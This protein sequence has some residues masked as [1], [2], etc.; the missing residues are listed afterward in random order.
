[1]ITRCSRVLLTFCGALQLVV[2]R[3]GL[4]HHAYSMFDVSRR[5]VISGTVRNLEWTNPHVWLWIAVADDEGKPAIYAFEGTSPGEMNR[6]NGWT[7]GTVSS[8]D[9]VTVRYLPFK[10]SAKKGGRIFSVTLA[11]GRTLGAAGG[12]SSPASGPAPRKQ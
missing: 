6:R 8:G 2:G 3:P 5:V 7:K 1:V 11:D 4:T 9:K 12:V 10:D